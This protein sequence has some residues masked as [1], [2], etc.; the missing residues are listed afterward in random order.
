MRAVCEQIEAKAESNRTAWRW[1]PYTILLSAIIAFSLL[2]WNPFPRLELTSLVLGISIPILVWGISR[3]RRQD[4]VPDVTAL[5]RRTNELSTLLEAIQDL[6]S[7]LDLEKVLA[8]IAEK[9]VQAAGADGCTISRWDRETDALITWIDHQP[10]NPGLADEPG[11]TYA[12]NDFPAAKGVLE[13]RQPLAIR[14]SDSDAD[15]AEVARLR[16]IKSASRLMLPLVIADHVIGLIELHDV[17]ER[18]FA[19]NE[20]HLCQALANQAAVAVENSRLYQESRRRLVELSTRSRAGIAISSSLDTQEILTTLTREAVHLLEAT[21]AYVCRWNET[22]RTTTVIAQHSSPHASLRE[23]SSNLGTAYTKDISVPEQLRDS[24]F[25]TLRASDP[26]LPLNWRNHL[27]LHG[28]QSALFL[29]LTSWRGTQAYLEVWESRY[30][31]TFTENEVLLGRNLASQAAVALDNAHLY[32]EAQQRLQEQIALRKAGAAISSALDLPTVLAHIAEQMGRTLDATS[33]YI[34]SYDPETLLAQVL[35]EY[36]GPEA[37]AAEQVSDLGTVYEE[38]GETDWLELMQAGKHDISHIDKPNLLESE[39]DHML[40]YGVK[41]ILYVP[42]RV[43]G[44]LIGYVEM[45]ESRRKREFTPQEISLCYDIAQYAAI[46]L[47]NAQL[48]EQAQK[49]I[50]ER[51]EAEERVKTSL[52]EKESLLQEIHHRVKNNLQ[53]ISSLLSLQSRRTADPAILEILSDSQGR[54]RS[55]ALV[56]EKLYQ[57]PDLAQ[58]DFGEYIRS[59]GQYLL[60]SYGGVRTGVLRLTVDASDALLDIDTAIPCGLMVNELITNSLKHAY[61][62]GQG[63]KIRVALCPDG[64]GQLTLTVSDDGI[65]LPDDVDFRNSPS[66]GLQLVN[67]LVMQLDGTIEL[68]RRGGTTFRVAFP[69]RGDGGV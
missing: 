28:G 68:D 61:P 42:L 48:Y 26:D 37:C 21:S 35:A 34:S 62:S 10:A 46:A 49:E 17:R 64:A 12:L 18:D 33:A 6:S 47:E 4:P 51:K 52:R 66:L 1:T 20:I 67:S 58:V 31:R 2:V 11:T 23:Q 3:L 30:D 14:V 57:S 50:V 44:E 22:Q 7:T 39:R 19:P 16:E 15:P 45:W 53:I 65:G 69:A 9:M 40:E 36:I 54:V 41:T 60:R 63:G 56:H 55:M 59:L 38:D 25:Y 43:K 5:E 24:P 32:A 27:E 13:A 8:T 29:P